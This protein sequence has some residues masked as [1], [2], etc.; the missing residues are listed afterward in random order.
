MFIRIDVHLH[1]GNG[2]E[3]RKLSP[4]RLFSDPPVHGSLSIR[5]GRFRRGRF[6]DDGF[7]IRESHRPRRPAQSEPASLLPL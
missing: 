5:S 7:R 2:S 6:S 3:F 4:V 1:P